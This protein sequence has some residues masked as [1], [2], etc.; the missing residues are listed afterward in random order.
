[1][2]FSVLQTARDEVTGFVCGRNVALGQPRKKALA[3]S[4]PHRGIED[5]LRRKSMMFTNLNAE[6]IAG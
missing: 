1:V 5:R 4:D 6:N 2:I 3:L